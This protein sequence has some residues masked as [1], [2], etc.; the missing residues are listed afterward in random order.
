MGICDSS[1]L[2][3]EHRQRVLV[4]VTNGQSY[5]CL[6]RNRKTYNNRFM[7][8]TPLLIS[9]YIFIFIHHNGRTRNGKTKSLPT[10]RRRLKILFWVGP[11][12]FGC[13]SCLEYLRLYAPWFFWPWRYIGHLLTYL[14]TYLQYKHYNRKYIRKKKDILINL[15]NTNFYN[16]TQAFQQ[17]HNIDKNRQES[18]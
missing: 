2:I 1:L 18:V 12:P 14:L 3:G 4:A 10:Y 6:R 9:I 5:C 8:Q 7:T 16:V 17:S 15:T 11:S 13:P